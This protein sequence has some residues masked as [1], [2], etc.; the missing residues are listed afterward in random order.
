MKKLIPIV[1]IVG[2]AGLLYWGYSLSTSMTGKL[3]KTF[4]GSPTD[5][6]MMLMIGGGICLVVGLLQ[7]WRAFKK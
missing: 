2:G 4:T 3:A 5:K 1:L 7:A 6:A